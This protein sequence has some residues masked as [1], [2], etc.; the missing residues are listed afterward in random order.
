MSLVSCDKEATVSSPFHAVKFNSVG[1]EQSKSQEVSSPQLAVRSSH[2][3]RSLC[4]QVK[5]QR[6]WWIKT[7]LQQSLVI[8]LVAVIA[9]MLT[10]NQRASIADTCHGR[11]T[12]SLVAAHVSQLLTGPC[13]SIRNLT[14]EL[15]SAMLQTWR[16]FVDKS[17]P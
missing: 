1:A 13:Y 8:V 17:D 14:A 10:A 3:L 7:D 11:K 15:N 12:P 5:K 6:K 4:C 2:H 9:L 16:A